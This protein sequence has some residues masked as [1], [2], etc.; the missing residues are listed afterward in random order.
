MT[1]NKKIV[2]ITGGSGAGKSYISQELRKMG[3]AVIDA[4][5]VAHECVNKSA[6]K[7][8]LCAFFGTDILSGGS[9]DRKKLGKLVFSNPEKLSKLNEI[10]HKYILSD[11]ADKI[12]E[13]K[14]DTVFVDGALLIESGMECDMMVGVLADKKERI[15]RIMRRDGITEEAAMERICAQKPDSFYK[16]KCDVILTNNGGTVDISAI[17]EG[18]KK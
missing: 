17:L 15:S 2:G 7:E 9:I 16:Q 12:A 14:G 5:E 13:E 4:D 1:Q 11:I 6:C 18:I 3:F 10:T 8:E